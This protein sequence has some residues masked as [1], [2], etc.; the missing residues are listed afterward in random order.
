MPTPEGDRRFCCIGCRQVYIMLSEAAG[1]TDPAAFRR[2]DLFRRC[3]EMGI[4]PRSQEDLAGRTR[5]RRPPAES[6]SPGGPR[7]E[8]LALHLQIDGMWCPACAWV[9][10][11]IIG[12][13]KGV[14]AAA[15][16]FS[17]DR[18][19]VEYDPVRI[20]P[21]QIREEIRRL[22]YGA[23]AH[24][25]QDRDPGRQAEFVRF[26][27]SAFL[28]MNVMMLSFA[29]YS[30]FFTF[31]PPDAVENLSW[32]IF[33]MATAVLA[34][35]GKTI[36]VRAVRAIPSGAFG[37]ETL[38]GAGAASAYLYSVYN[39]AA[40]SVHLYFDTAAM[41]ITLVL[42]GKLLERK[43]K[44]QVQQDLLTVFSLKPAK[45]RI[46][47]EA[48]PKGRYLPAESLTAGSLF[49]IQEG[50]RA[51]ADGRIVDGSGALDESSITGESAAVKKRTGERVVSGSRVLEGSFLVR[52]EATGADSVLGRMIRI[53][54]AALAEKT[55]LEAKTDRMLRY[56]VPLILLLAAATG[57]GCLL[58]GKPTET[59]VIRAVTVMVIA[60]PCALGIAV[61][62]ARVAGIS[63]AGRRGILVREFSA[64][65]EAEAVDAVVFDKT[66]TLTQGRWELLQI[67]PLAEHDE[68]A[69]L[70]AAAGLEAGSEHPIALEIGRQAR[71]RGV[72]PAEFSR[73]RAEETG[74]SGRLGA[75][76][77]RIG[78]RTFADPAGDGEAVWKNA[79]Q[80]IDSARSM[81]YMTVGGRPAGLFVFG[82]RIREGSLPAARRLSADGYRLSVVSG[83]GPGATAAVASA[84]GIKE[85][86][87]G[88][89]PD[90][91]A[92]W[93][94]A[95]RR[96]G[97]RVAMVGDGVND[98]PAM[99]RADFGV[100][101]HAG[102]ALGGEAAHVTLMQS[103]PMQLV[104][105]F[106]LSR[107]V[108]RK[109]QQ[110]LVFSFL[111]NTISIPVA[112]AGLL[113][114]LV[115][116]TAMLCSS[117]TVIG[118]TLF[119]IRSRAKRNR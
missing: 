106:H 107:R 86:R 73:V 59:A 113:T 30:G 42:L 77:V 111:Y 118:N 38:V 18:L 81:V 17:T 71:R 116:V 93:V 104:T 5:T 36:F 82:D 24:D 14:L 27:V 58:A 12:R 55:P 109:I 65:E 8:G 114:P 20:T 52:A 99:A 79:A 87:G 57:L 53:M 119:L 28:T 26:S 19:R 15:C 40:G 51:A 37:M 46:V 45:V 61:P 108:N 4:I 98:A 75:D 100:A 16:N 94:D 66:G 103:D 68:A 48:D 105:F 21:E 95:I 85:V 88:A 80:A 56:L 96:E 7:P 23:A 78:N 33:F 54:E 74:I 90:E 32:P 101:V 9:I 76:T 22:G 84:L 31:L 91:K 112:M 92:A 41:L 63:L 97:S 62:L 39:F 11:E 89:T 83:D 10:E 34:Y 102:G 115:A 3:Q 117:L 60:C 44:D 43:A 1:A 72:A 35:G 70:S 13:R 69:L 50:E 67:R 64:F 49:R 29:L 25:E 110:N 2:T 47:T 6:D